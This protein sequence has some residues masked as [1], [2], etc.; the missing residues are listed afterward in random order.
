MNIDEKS[1][2]LAVRDASKG[3]DAKTDILQS[4]SSSITNVE[5]WPLDLESFESVLA[6]GNR[7]TS[8][9]RGY[10]F[11]ERLESLHVSC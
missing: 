5:V 6:L 2:K 10:L 9:P 11:F 3:E 1:P 7:A 4:N 8:L